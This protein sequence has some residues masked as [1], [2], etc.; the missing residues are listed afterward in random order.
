MSL[1]FT[2]LATDGN[3]RRGAVET[4]GYFGQYVSF[5]DAPRR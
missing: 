5:D 1:K 2:L 4:P 3:A